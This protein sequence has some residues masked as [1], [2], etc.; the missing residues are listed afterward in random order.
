MDTHAL[1]V[2]AHPFT[3]SLPSLTFM[4]ASGEVMRVALPKE[5]SVT[6][7]HRT[8]LTNAT[9]ARSPVSVFPYFL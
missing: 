4:Y 7:T 9:M 5:I 3:G 8:S 1:I 2:N 6:G